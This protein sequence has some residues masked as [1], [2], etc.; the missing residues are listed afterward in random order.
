MPAWIRTAAFALAMA[1]TVT[2]S[3]SLRQKAMTQFLDTQHYQDIYYLPP[4][5]WLPVFSLGYQKALCDLIWMKAL[6][7]F[8][9]EIAHRGNVRHLYEYADAMI[10]LDKHFKPVYRWAAG[11]SLYRTGQITVK[12]ARKAVEY[13]KRGVRLF[14]NDGE[15]A[16][17]LGATYLYEL[18]PMLTDPTEKAEARKQAVPYLQAAALRGAGPPWLA[19]TNATQLEKLGKT[20]QAIRHLEALYST[21][22]NPDTREE[23]EKRLAT[24][25]NWSYV[26]AMRHAVRELKQ[27][28]QRDFPYL[29]LTLYLLVGPRPLIDEAA[30]IL[31]NFD[32]LADIAVEEASLEN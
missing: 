27:A 21:T 26:E 12:D 2:A 17:D 20:E 10:E 32:P 30:L 25:R 24:L 22:A 28:H 1:L 18:A 6:V 31:N 29:S 23:I 11:S 5:E 9:E 8:G 19:L 3:N 14:P 13:L 16:W 7:Y 4:T 15:L